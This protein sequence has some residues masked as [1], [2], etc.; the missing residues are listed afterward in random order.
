[1]AI[2]TTKRARNNVTYPSNSN[3]KRI[4]VDVNVARAYTGRIFRRVAARVTVSEP[5]AAG[6]KRR[7][8]S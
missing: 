4:D 5:L 7:V 8:E 1:M 3:S 2:E 6:Y